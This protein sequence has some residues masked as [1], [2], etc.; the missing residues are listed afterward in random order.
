MLRAT[1]E[2]DLH[3][4]ANVDRRPITVLTHRVPEQPKEDLPPSFISGLNHK[5]HHCKRD[6][7]RV[8]RLS[9]CSKCKLVRYC[10]KEHQRCDWFKHR[11]ECE[12]IEQGVKL[13][14]G[15]EKRLLPWG[16]GYKQYLAYEGFEQDRKATDGEVAPIG[17]PD[18]TIK[19]KYSKFPYFP[20]N[21]CL[22]RRLHLHLF[23]LVPTLDSFC[24]R[25]PSTSSVSA[26]TKCYDFL[27]WYI[28]IAPTY[29]FTN[30]SLPFLD[31]HNADALKSID[32]ITQ[33]N[34]MDLDLSVL[35]AMT[36]LKLRIGI[37]LRNRAGQ[38]DQDFASAIIAANPALHKIDR[39]EILEPQVE[40]LYGLVKKRNKHFWPIL[41]AEEN[42]IMMDG[43]N[44]RASLDTGLERGGVDEAKACVADAWEAFRDQEGLVEMVRRGVMEM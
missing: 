27:K 34:W 13:V 4:T 44:L 43:F 40:V 15:E 22:K 11:E 9:L 33:G 8:D 3:L 28:T 19:G 6:A 5:C 42:V 24:A 20:Y 38:E 17:R 14:A 2:I 26:K 35:V 1:C 37:I 31:I 29:N 41:L 10:S 18:E 23:H 12:M 30:L 39:F 36:L 25:Q 21:Y 16:L 7:S 32:Y